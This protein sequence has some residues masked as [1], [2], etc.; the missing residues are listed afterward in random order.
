VGSRTEQTLELPIS[1]LKIPSMILTTSPSLQQSINAMTVPGVLVAH[2]M[3]MPGDE[4][5]LLPGEAAAFANSVSKVRRASAA[6]RIVARDLLPR[7]GVPPQPIPKSPSGVPVWPTGIVGS[8]AHDSSV[9]VAAIALGR[10]FLAVGIDIEPDNALDPDLIH[11][12]A[13]AQERQAIGEDR[14]RARLLFSIKEAVYKA[15]YPLDRVFLDHHDVEVCLE[16]GT[17]TVRNGRLL[18]FRYCIAANI[19][20]LAFIAADSSGL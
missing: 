7:L 9:A 20:S 11:I 19:V 5:A 17:A 4:Q 14:Y 10:D 13:T 6:A 15:V 8:L 18:R 12:V 1:I 2:R 16:T 3:I